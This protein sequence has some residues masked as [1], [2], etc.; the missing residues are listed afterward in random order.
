MTQSRVKPRPPTS[1]RGLRDKLRENLTRRTILVGAVVL[2]VA[3]L[4]VVPLV[5]LVTGTFTA[6]DGGFTLNGFI[7]AYGGNSQAGQMFVNS[8]IFAV[9]SAA[10]ALAIGTALAYVQVRTDAPGKGLLFA[11]SMVPLIIPGVLY[12]ISWIFLANPTV[13][14]L[15]TA[16]FQPLF[17]Q[18]L[19][20]YGMPGMIWVEGTHMAPLAF[21][22]MVGAF[23]AMDP[24]LEES[25]SMS[26]ARTATA[27]VKVTLPLVRPALIAAAL[28]MFVRALSAFEIPTLLGVPKGE[29]V[30]TSRIYHE[31]QNVPVNYSAA[32]AYSIGLLIVA[33]LGLWL[34]SYLNRNSRSYQTISGK[35]FRPRKIA[36]GRARPWVGALTTFYF[37]LAVVLPVL[38]LFYTSLLSFYQGLSWKALGQLSFDNYVRIFKA[39]GTWDALQNSMILAVGAATIVM[40]LT[41]IASWVVVRTKLPGRRAIDTLAFMPLVIPG[42]VLGVALLFV[43]LRTTLPIYGTLL[44]LL[45]AFCTIN[46]PYGMQYASAAM[47]QISTE[48]EESATVFGASWWTTFRRILLPLASGG[49]VAGW[50]YVAII[51]F[52]EL[53]AA[54]L[55]YSPGNEVISVLIWQQYES[56]S[57]MG[58]SALGILLIT[59][60][61]VVVAVAYK[62]GASVG[63]QKGNQ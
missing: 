22:L 55:V 8:L 12:A 58:L 50:I 41:A 51:S 1:F 18:S 19:D 16:I 44:I 60:L 45:I 17:G 49:I 15:N 24:S 6:G 33:V 54:I 11:A 29:Y 59:I 37:V 46:L 26:G 38:A 36:L 42:I 48:L 35:A 57:F 32:G 28:L 5:Y 31:L 63:L 9:G 30:F 13:G 43:Y 61:T 47:R 20:I 56:G 3:Y 4:A 27:F 34:T 40:L 14:I 23:Q 21:L 7:R 10:L 2:I 62:L 39:S 25:A 52:R 53:S